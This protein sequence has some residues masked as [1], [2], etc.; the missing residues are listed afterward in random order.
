LH[1]PPKFPCKCAD[2]AQRSP[3]EIGFGSFRISLRTVKPPHEVGGSSWLAVVLD[4]TVECG[5]SS[6]LKQ[7][8]IEGYL[9]D[10]LVIRPAA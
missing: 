6:E 2:V 10:E 7:E 5:R 1:K 9:I 4:R 8:L 3:P